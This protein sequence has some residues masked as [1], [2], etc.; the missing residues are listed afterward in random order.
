[1]TRWLAGVFDPSGRGDCSR[2]SRALD[3]HA[4]TLLVNGPLRVAHTGAGNDAGTPL[5]LLDGYLDNAAELST[6]LGSHA[7][8]PHEAL[9]AAGWRRWGRELPARMRGEFALLIWDEALGEGLLARD[10]LGVRSMFLHEASG[11]LCFASEVRHLLAL[12]PRRPAPDPVSV[13]H[14]ITMSNR[15]GSATLYAGIRR[16]NPGAA[17]L[18]E[19]AGTR[20]VTYWEPRFT[21]PL[22]DSEPELAQQVRASLSGAVG[23]RVSPDGLT[24]VL[25]SGGLDSSSVA[26]A[27]AAQAPGRITAQAAVF[28]EHPAV[29]ESGL[30]DELRQALDLPGITAEVRAGGLLAS[31]LESIGEWELPLRSWGDFWALPLLRAA[32]AGGVRVTLGG[33]GGDELFGARSH[34]SADRVRA[35]HPLQALALVRELPGAGDHPPRREVARIFANTALTGA[36]P[37]RLHEMLPQRLHA[38]SDTREWLRP[39]LARDLRHSD[40]PLAWKRLDGPRWWAGVAHGLTRGVEETGVFEHQRR[41]AAS[42]GLQARHPLFDLELVE[43]GLRLPP[44]STFD[45]HRSRPV[46]RAA[47]AGL[48]PDSVRLR[49]QKA[50]FDSLLIDCLAGA[51]GLLARELLSDPRAEL[52]A[53]VD[54]PAMTSTLFD[55][56]ADAR[57]RSFQWMWQIWRLLS[58]ECWLRSQAAG[59]ASA[60]AQRATAPR[61]EMRTA[62]IGAAPHG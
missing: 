52:R 33:D 26:A 53:Y 39:E 38:R 29:D 19:P 48:L 12:L 4:A 21:E 47:M 31:A 10:Q 46:L 13:A 25:M 56:V 50:L 2:L 22:S 5:C 42:A 16:L 3:P 32:A 61:V 49:P 30:I 34:L 15:P 37:Y 11:A 62:A 1:M 40:D 28:P 7:E 17:L 27:A 9:L 41:R 60:V 14:W 57:E 54:L 8:E 23:R 59:G 18:L 24:G 55:P 51:D 58:A 20:E 35:G 45:R 6:A 44:T 36:L 43:L